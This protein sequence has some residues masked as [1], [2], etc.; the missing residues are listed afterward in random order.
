MN[1]LAGENRLVVTATKSGFQYNFARFG[2][3]M[4]QA[5]GDTAADLDKDGQTSLLEAFLLASAGVAEFYELE[6]RLP[7]ENAL[8]DDNGDGL[9]TPA[10]WF[11]GVRAVQ[12]PKNDALADG[13]RANQLHLVRSDRERR[14]PA[15]LRVRRDQLE[16]EI[17][18]LREKKSQLDE[19]DYYRQIESL[20][21]ELAQLYHSLDESSAL[22]SPL[23]PPLR[24]LHDFEASF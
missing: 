15:E 11:R 12:K 9:G 22:I 3:Y 14:M 21:L 1:Q 13:L 17:A 19:D 10:D 16:S 23:R 4:A 24:V 2:K 18:K 7:T 6:A 5:I 20:F 8:L